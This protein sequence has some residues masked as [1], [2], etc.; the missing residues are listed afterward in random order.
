[1]QGQPLAS[2]WELGF[3]EGSH[4]ALIRM[5]TM[6]KLSMQTIQFDD[7][8]LL[9]SGGLAFWSVLSGGWLCDQPPVTALGTESLGDNFYS[10][11]NLLP[12]ALSNNVCDM[13]G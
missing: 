12:E 13:T 5:V 8:Y 2:V 9:F 1:M 7:E 3:G 10:C 4:H 6:P 11:Y